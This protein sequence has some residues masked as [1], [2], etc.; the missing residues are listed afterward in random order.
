MNIVGVCTGCRQNVL[1]FQITPPNDRYPCSP[2]TS[3]R[4][5]P[6]QRS[7]GGFSTTASPQLTRRPLW[8]KGYAQRYSGI[9]LKAASEGQ[10]A[11]LSSE[12]T[13]TMNG[14][15][16]YD[17]ACSGSEV[18][19]GAF[20]EWRVEESD[21]KEVLGYRAGL[22][23]AALGMHQHDLMVLFCNLERSAHGRLVLHASCALDCAHDMAHCSMHR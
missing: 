10:Q 11:L 7:S 8:S 12:I 2:S 17:D 13:C 18:Y 4:F 16:S 9:S 1:A 15:Y 5:S 23:V 14:K 20:G 22:S 6:Q 3:G 21:V 19:Q